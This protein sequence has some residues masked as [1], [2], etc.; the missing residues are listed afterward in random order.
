[1]VA[2]QE[3]FAILTICSSFQQFEH[4]LICYSKE[5]YQAGFVPAKI[6]RRRPQTPFCPADLD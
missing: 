5:I 3:P 6:D 2:G 1:M 4:C